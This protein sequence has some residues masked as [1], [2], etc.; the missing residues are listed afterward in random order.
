[1]PPRRAHG[2]AVDI[3]LRLNL[4]DELLRRAMD[5]GLAET[6]AIY[7]Q[8]EVIT[9]RELD[10]R[11]SRLAGGLRSVGV[12]PTDRVLLRFPNRPEFVVAWFALQK[13]GAVVLATMPLLRAREL[14]Y[15]AND[16]RVKV[17]LV[18]SDL[19]EE[20]EKARPQ[21]KTIEKIVV[22][23]GNAA[24]SPT[25]EELAGFEAVPS[26]EIGRDDPALIAYTS[27]STGVPKGCVHF[28]SDVLA[29]ADTYGKQVLAPEPGDIF[30]GHPPLA[31]TFGLGGLLVYPLRFGAATCLIERSRPRPCWKPSPGTVRP[32]RSALR[33]PTSS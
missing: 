29:S 28:P 21:F 8:D 27:G 10:Q 1:M 17:A 19:Y 32:E 22:S 24:E 13:L 11:A 31:F 2:V 4:A 33:L 25:F 15:V 9:Y 16:S 18:S 30:T 6:P 5:S 26:V 23:G 14:E 12:E 3:P 20:M 7:Y